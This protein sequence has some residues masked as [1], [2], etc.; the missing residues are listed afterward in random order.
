MAARQ[1][2][3]T[4]LAHQVHPAKIT[5]DV[6]ASALVQHAAM[7]GR[8]KA[9][10]AVRIVLP[11][12]GPLAVLTPADLDARPDRTGTVRARAHAAAGQVVRLAG[13][14]LTAHRAR[15]RNWALLL[16]D[17]AVIAASRSHAAWPRTSTR[18]R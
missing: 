15:R 14:A 4:M 8:P 7:A 5:A 3:G 12:G 1:L 6:T 16:A 10:L 11:A 17:A 13:D 9:A 18:A 2:A